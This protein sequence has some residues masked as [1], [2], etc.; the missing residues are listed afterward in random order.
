M[1]EKKQKK[2]KK[3]KKKKNR[4]NTNSHRKGSVI[5]I[6]D[7]DVFVRRRSSTIGVGSKLVIN[8]VVCG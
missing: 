3:K 1:E 4:I 2:D 7:G 8:R 5:F 6:R